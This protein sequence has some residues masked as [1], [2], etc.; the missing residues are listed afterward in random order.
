MIPALPSRQQLTS[1]VMW[2]AAFGA[3]FGALHMLTYLQEGNL[4]S[5]YDAL[6]NAGIGG[7]LRLVT[8]FLLRSGKA[9]AIVVE[10]IGVLCSIGFALLLGRGFNYISLVLG[11]LFVF[12]LI[13]LWRQ[14]VLS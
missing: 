7:A 1:I 10:V 12:W 13:N 14:K 11:G 5:L 6:F 2:G 8:Y 3:A 4:T 9:L